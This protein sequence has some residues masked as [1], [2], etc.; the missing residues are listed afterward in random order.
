VS[1]DNSET[2]GAAAA[3]AQPLEG[4]REMGR[5]AEGDRVWIAP[6]G[7]PLPEQGLEG[8]APAPAT[9]D[10]TWGGYSCTLQAGHEGLHR[11]EAGERFSWVQWTEEAAR[12]AREV[13]GS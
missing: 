5:T 4:W 2:A 13:P 8:E 12:S 6:V 7:T 9:C 1:G 11:Q 3:E 10:S